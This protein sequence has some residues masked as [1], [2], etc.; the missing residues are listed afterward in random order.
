MHIC[1]KIILM[2]MV[3]VCQCVTEQQQDNFLDASK[4]CLHLPSEEQMSTVQPTTVNSMVSC[5]MQVLKARIPPEIKLTGF[6]RQYAFTPCVDAIIFYTEKQQFCSDPQADWITQRLE[7]LVLESLKTL[8][9]T[10]PEEH[11]PTLIHIVNS[12]QSYAENV[13]CCKTVST[14]EVIDSIIGFRMQKS[15]TTCVKAVIFKTEKGEFCSHWRQPWV[16]KKIRQFLAQRKM[17]AEKHVL[18]HLTSSPTP[19]TSISHTTFV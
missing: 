14:K 5:C 7:E 16:L 9:S 2:L 18:E 15:D 13:T 19:T 11:D 12:N 17:L 10:A 3:L 1:W 4:F 8:N 6:K